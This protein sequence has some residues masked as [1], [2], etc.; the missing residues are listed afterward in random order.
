MKI[1]H[2]VTYAKAGGVAQKAAHERL[3]CN[4]YGGFCAHVRQWP[5]ARAVP[6]GQNESGVRQLGFLE[7]HVGERQAVPLAMLYEKTS[8]R[9]G[10]I[11]TGLSG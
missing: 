6:C 2:E 3:T 9:I 11:I 10:H 5:E 8:V 7:K 1:Q 4:R